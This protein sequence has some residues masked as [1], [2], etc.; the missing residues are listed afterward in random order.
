MIRGF[1]D[2]M[3]ALGFPEFGEAQLKYRKGYCGEACDK[4][5]HLLQ[6]LNPRIYSKYHITKKI[7]QII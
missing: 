6:N 5:L 4:L 7:N 3:V 2:E 1:S